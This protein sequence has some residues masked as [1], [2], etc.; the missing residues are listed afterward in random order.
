MDKAN[1]RFVLSRKFRLQWDGEERN[2]IKEAIIYTFPLFQS[3]SPQVIFEAARFLVT[4]INTNGLRDSLE[5]RIADCRAWRCSGQPFKVQYMK[6]YLPRHCTD[7]KPFIRAR[8]AYEP[9]C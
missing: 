9:L 3:D 6:I 1:N 5:Q 8:I 7:P 2:L 4:L